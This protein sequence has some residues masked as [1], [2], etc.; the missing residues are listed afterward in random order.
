MR[1]EPESGELRMRRQAVDDRWAALKNLNEQGLRDAESETTTF[2]E[3]DL[4]A[5][6]ARFAASPRRCR[7][8]ELPRAEIA[9]PRVPALWPL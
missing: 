1:A 8:P 7:V 2:Q 9:A 3:T 5:P 4:R 6:H